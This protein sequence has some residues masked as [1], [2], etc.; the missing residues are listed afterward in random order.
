MP[1]PTHAGDNLHDYMGKGDTTEADGAGQD[2][3][4]DHGHPDENRDASVPPRPV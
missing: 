2:R 3:R 1:R 4:D